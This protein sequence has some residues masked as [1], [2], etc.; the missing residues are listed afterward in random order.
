MK[1]VVL[2][3][4]VNV[5]G[6]NKVPM[7]QL[8]ESLEAAGYGAVSTYIASGNVVLESDKQ[9]KEIQAEIEQLLPRV[10]DLD[11]ELVKALV[12]TR[13]QLKAIIDGRPDGF[14]EQADTY[15]SDAVFLID[16]DIQQAM[17]VFDPREGVDRVWPGK[18]VVYSQRLSAER[19]KSRLGKII[20]TPVYASMTIRSWNT[21]VK[22]LELLS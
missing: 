11:S 19:T 17:A 22:L 18:G 3:R 6:K 16:V 1:Y 2:L 9:P 15:H 13:D 5:G 10:F 8:R 7:A 20:G 14:G 21:T 4:G 12:L